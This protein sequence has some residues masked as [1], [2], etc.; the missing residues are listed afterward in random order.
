MSYIVTY[1]IKILL[2]LLAYLAGLQT[3]QVV[4]ISFQASTS[5]SGTMGHEV[6]PAHPKLHQ[7]SLYS[8]ELDGTVRKHKE[9]ISISNGLA[10][11]ADNRTMYYIDSVPRKVWAY[12]FDLTTGTMSE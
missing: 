3:K 12:D 8:F 5:I 11:S 1:M 2:L 9:N 4:F 7:G 6:V 10:W